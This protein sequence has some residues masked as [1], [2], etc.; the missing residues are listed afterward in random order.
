MPAANPVGLVLIL[1]ASLRCVDSKSEVPGLVQAALGPEGA[2]R[3]QH[4]PEMAPPPMALPRHLA[5]S[6]APCQGQLL[7]DV[8]SPSC[9][10]PTDAPYCIFKCKAFMYKYIPWEIKL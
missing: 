10:K 8:S 7:K 9:Y 5:L 3:G 4:T 2:W 1:A 6:K